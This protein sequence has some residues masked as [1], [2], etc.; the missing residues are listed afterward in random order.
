MRTGTPYIANVAPS[1][2]VL[3][4]DITNSSVGNQYT[5]D[6][7]AAGVEKRLVYIKYK[8]EPYTGKGTIKLLNQDSA[9]NSIPFIGA[10]AAI[11]WGWSG[12]TK[13]VEEPVWVVAAKNVS[14]EGILY[15]QLEVVNAWELLKYSKGLNIADVAGDVPSTNRGWDGTTDILT[16]ITAIVSDAN[17]WLGQWGYTS[18]TQLNDDQV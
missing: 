14:E 3:F 18:V 11:S 6:T 16:I 1:V 2:S 5:N 4:K 17:G 8:S 15:L 7:T 13:S 9:L 10:R 12:G